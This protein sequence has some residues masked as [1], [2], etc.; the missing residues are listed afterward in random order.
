METADSNTE[1]NSTIETDTTSDLD[2]YYRLMF[3]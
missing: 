3:P 2:N 1:E